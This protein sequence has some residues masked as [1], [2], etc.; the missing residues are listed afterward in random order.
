M[1]VNKIRKDGVD[2]DITSKEIYST[3]EQVIGKWIDG[4]PLYRKQ[5]NLQQRP[6]MLNGY[7]MSMEYLMLNI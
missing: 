6:V 7:N 2:Y 4:K 5:Y 1:S 3:E